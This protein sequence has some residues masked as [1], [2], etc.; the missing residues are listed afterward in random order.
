MLDS[1]ASEPRVKNGVQVQQLTALVAIQQV[2]TAGG[3]NV[4]A[5]VL[6]ESG[7]FANPRPGPGGTPNPVRG[8]SPVF[9]LDNPSA[10]VRAGNTAKAF[11]I[12]TPRIARN[13]G[14]GPAV[15]GRPK[16]FGG[17]GQQ[18]PSMTVL[19]DRSWQ[20]V[21]P[22]DEPLDSLSPRFDYVDELQ[23][24]ALER[25]SCDST[26][27]W[28]D[29]EP[30]DGPSGPTQPPTEM[31]ASDRTEDPS[32]QSG[33][34]GRPSVSALMALLL[35]VSRPLLGLFHEPGSPTLRRG[36]IQNPGRSKSDEE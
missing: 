15:T 26:P 23:D 22:G 28:R 2:S 34:A 18:G 35:S 12:L 14:A 30:S 36:R 1:G 33:D 8:N 11:G 19:P 13:G 7:Q 3:A 16:G 21:G 10:R 17:R 25:A 27:M 6:R 29:G 31:P 5:P 32:A 20:E 9:A 24:L 4:A